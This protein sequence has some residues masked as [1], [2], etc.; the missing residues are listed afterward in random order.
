MQEK[1]SKNEAV[2]SY[3][4]WRVMPDGEIRHVEKRLRIYPDRLREPDWWAKLHFGVPWMADQWN[5]FM[6]AWALACELAGIKKI[7]IQTEL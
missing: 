4:D 5:T 7:E 1:K 2:G 3:G 6:P